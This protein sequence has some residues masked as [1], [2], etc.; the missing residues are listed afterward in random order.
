MTVSVTGINAGTTRSGRAEDIW[1]SRRVGMY[2]V[3]MDSSYL[4]GG[5]LFDPRAFGFDKPVAA[6]FLSVHSVAAA[7]TRRFEYDFVNKT[8]KGVVTS[9]GAEIASG[10]D[11]S[12]IVIDALV[13]GE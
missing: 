3:T 10:Q 8:I 2:Q 5:E 13:I 4:T 6:V 1:G 11:L 12:T 7:V 9:T